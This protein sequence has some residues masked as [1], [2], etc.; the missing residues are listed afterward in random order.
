MHTYY[1]FTVKNNIKVKRHTIKTD[2]LICL[3]GGYIQTRILSEEI[4]FLS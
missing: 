1:M 2:S 3:V 4:I